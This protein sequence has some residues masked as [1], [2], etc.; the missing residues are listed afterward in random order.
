MLLYEGSLLSF[1]TKSSSPFP[2]GGG[3]AVANNNLVVTFSGV[4]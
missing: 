1:D 4:G 3:V 2:L